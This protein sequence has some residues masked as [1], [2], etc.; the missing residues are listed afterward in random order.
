MI[1]Q[2]A[3]F[4]AEFDPKIANVVRSARK[5]LRAWLAL[6]H[7]TR[8]QWCR[9]MSRLSLHATL[10]VEYEFGLSVYDILAQDTLEVSEELVLPRGALEHVDVA[11]IVSQD[12]SAVECGN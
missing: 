4:V 7:S 11:V 10:H 5:E 1:K 6:L 12:R 9:P 8:P 3:A 2:L